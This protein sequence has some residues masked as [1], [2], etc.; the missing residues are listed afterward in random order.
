VKVDIS[1]LF[2]S[3]DK[4]TRIFFQIFPS[5]LKFNTAGVEPGDIPN[6]TDVTVAIGF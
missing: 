4:F 1:I 2:S 3:D 5:K 6:T